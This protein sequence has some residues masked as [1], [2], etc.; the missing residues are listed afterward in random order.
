MVCMCI[1]ECLQNHVPMLALLRQMEDKLSFLQTA[2]VVSP[3]FVSPGY[4]MTFKFDRDTELNMFF[5]R[6][7]EDTDFHDVSVLLKNDNPLQ[8]PVSKP[9]NSFL[10]CSICDVWSRFVLYH[11]KIGIK[12]SRHSV[13][14]PDNPA[15]QIKDENTM[16]NGEIKGDTVSTSS[17][18]RTELNQINMTHLTCSQFE[19]ILDMWCG[20]PV[21]L[22]SECALKLVVIMESDNISNS[23]RG[24]MIHFIKQNIDALCCAEFVNMISTTP[25]N[26]LCEDMQFFF[27]AN[28][29]DVMKYVNGKLSKEWKTFVSENVN[30]IESTDSKQTQQYLKAN[31]VKVH[32]SFQGLD[33]GL[34]L[35]VLQFQTLPYTCVQGNGTL[36]LQSGSIVNGRLSVISM[37]MFDSRS[38]LVILSDRR[39][40][41][42]DVVAGVTLSEKLFDEDEFQGGR[43]ADAMI[44]HDGIYLVMLRSDMIDNNTFEPKILVF[45]KDTGENFLKTARCELPIDT[46]GIRLNGCSIVGNSKVL[47]VTIWDSR[48]SVHYI[49]VKDNQE[50]TCVHV[51]ENRVR[52][53]TIGVFVIDSSVFF[54]HNQSHIWQVER[55]GS[56]KNQFSDKIRFDAIGIEFK[57]TCT[58]MGKLYYCL[59][60]PEPRL[61]C[62]D[63]SPSNTFSTNKPW[64]GPENRII[65]SQL[66]SSG[67]RLLMYSSSDEE[68][69]LDVFDVRTSSFI[70]S[71]RLDLAPMRAY[72][73]PLVDRFFSLSGRLCFWYERDRA[74]F[75]VL[76]PQIQA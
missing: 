55:D 22:N 23:L 42:F 9:T 20:I 54:V 15:T 39:I 69:R 59:M 67:A 32:D 33:V 76:L 52:Y 10:L 44:T 68:H 45:D 38:L 28:F 18:N 12:R 2:A 6:C 3:A 70:Q 13:D 40:V 49:Y 60:K 73:A 26:Q 72:Y 16:S 75:D 58:F 17:E 19:M 48:G 71:I 64:S 65:S 63:Q 61:I 31:D 56:D 29:N 37:H 57:S 21:Q 46:G 4:E 14:V 74:R 5:S 36:T 50:Y 11:S 53:D 47:V 1:K 7:R 34:P 24:E 66:I 25:V 41:I 62:V 30:F 43:A 8:S 27:L 51:R 35:N